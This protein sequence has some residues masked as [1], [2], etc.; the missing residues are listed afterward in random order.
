MSAPPRQE[1]LQLGE[2][3]QALIIDEQFEAVIE[4]MLQTARA[5]ADV[6]RDPYRRQ[7]M[8][9]FAKGLT[10]LRHGP[11]VRSADIPR[12]A[13]RE[14]ISIALQRLM[15]RV[16]RLRELGKLPEQDQEWIE[17]LGVRL[18]DL[19]HGLGQQ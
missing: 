13:G 17:Q 4:T 12:P 5:N 8:I 15:L 10:K 11:P 2:M 9:W 16:N 3:I 18:N 19:W 7:R 6:E 1:L 14:A